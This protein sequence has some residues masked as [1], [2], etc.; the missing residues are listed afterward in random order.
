MSDTL[1]SDQAS[2]CSRHERT[3]LGGILQLNIF[4]LKESTT[5]GVVTVDKEE[6]SRAR[7]RSNQGAGSMEGHPPP[8]NIYT[9][10]SSGMFNK[11]PVDFIERHSNMDSGMSEGRSSSLISCSNVSDIGRAALE[12]G[13]IDDPL[14][15]KKIGAQRSL[16][17]PFSSSSSSCMPIA[18]SS[19]TSLSSLT[20]LLPTSALPSHLFSHSLSGVSPVL[21]SLSLSAPNASASSPL[22]QQQ[23]RSQSQCQPQQIVSL[24]TALEV[25]SVELRHSKPQIAGEP[26]DHSAQSELS[27]A[28]LPAEGPAIQAELQQQA[29]TETVSEQH[30]EASRVTILLNSSPLANNEVLTSRA[31]G[32]GLK[33]PLRRF[34]AEREEYKGSV[35]GYVDGGCPWETWDEAT[36]QLDG[37]CCVCMVGLKGAAFIPCG[38]TFCRKCSRELW[39]G[40]GT[41]PLCNRYIREILDIF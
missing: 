7:S 20:P 27:Q 32:R 18:F 21:P 10:T 22:Q 37:M 38:H 2:S 17:L 29:A 40:R 14:S 41:C 9:E 11:F 4:K 31:K 30:A 3:T 24:S 1:W 28:F 23:A 33:L 13:A 5:R 25:E 35:S 6:S 8:S 36:E 19:P 16:N 12:C 15:N 26:N 39:K 34:L